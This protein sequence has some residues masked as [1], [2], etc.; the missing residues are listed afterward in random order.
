MLEHPF[1]VNQ[2]LN[3]LMFAVKE[4][5]SSDLTIHVC[6]YLLSNKLFESCKIPL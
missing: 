4:L 6:L 3:E 2:L 5:T 1:D